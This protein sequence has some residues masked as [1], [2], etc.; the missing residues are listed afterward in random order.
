MTEEQLSLAIDAAEP[1]DRLT[2]RFR[3]MQP[4]PRDAP[5]EDP[6]YFFEPW[7]PGTRA[8]VSHQ[9]GRLTVRIEHLADPLTTFPELVALPDQLSGDGLLLDGTLLVLDSDGRPDADLLRRRL[10]GT[11]P[12]AG[13]AAYVASDLLHVSGTSLQARPFAERR[14]QLTQLVEDGERCV[15]SRGVHADGETLAEA[16]ASMGLGEISAR[17]L[18]SRYRPGPAGEAWFRMPVTQVPATQARP[19][20]ALL[21]RLPL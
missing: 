21:Q 7:W 13:A 9:T 6:H 14:G 20:L 18:A 11:L 10:D 8:F 15:V 1:L 5:F 19:L 3:P 16:V 17:H 4:T 12:G 2:H